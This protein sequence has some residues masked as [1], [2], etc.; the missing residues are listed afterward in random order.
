MGWQLPLAGMN[1]HRMAKHLLFI[2]SRNQ[3]RSPTGEAVLAGYPGVETDSA[4]LSPDAEVRLS[5]EQVEWA[6]IVFVME[7]KHLAK[8]NGMFPK[9]LGG[10]KVVVLNIPDNYEYMQPELVGLLR[11]RCEPYLK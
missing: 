9:A 2:C 11:K 5:E 7:K 6:D 8:I 1:S 3:L 10:K 4:G